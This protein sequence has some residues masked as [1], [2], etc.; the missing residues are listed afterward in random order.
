MKKQIEIS[1]KLPKLIGLIAICLSVSVFILSDIYDK[2]TSSDFFT[3]S[4]FINY[5]LALGYFSFILLRRIIFQGWNIFKLDGGSFRLFVVLFTISAFA[6]NRSMRAFS[7]PVLWLEIY[8]IITQIALILYA[9]KEKLSDNVKEAI[10]FI[11]GAGATIALY[12]SI[13]LFPISV[14]GLLFCWFFGISLNGIIQWIWLAVF[15]I[16]VFKIKSRPAKISFLT[17]AVIPIFIAIF[18][19]FK[20]SQT[21]ELVK[22]TNA[23]INKD[24]PEWVMLSQNLPDD[25]FTEWAMESD[26]INETRTD[27]WGF[28]MWGFGSSN[29]IKRHDPFTMIS[30]NILGDLGI[31]RDNQIKILETKFKYRHEAI[32]RLWSDDDLIT[33]N[34]ETEVELMPDY[35]LA[36]IEKK[37]TIENTYYDPHGWWSPEGEAVYTF[38]LPEGAVATSLSLWINGVEEKARLTTKEK[39]DSAYTTI[40]GVEVRDPSVVHWQ[41]GNRLIVRVFPCTPKEDRKFKLGVTVPLRINDN[42]LIFD[43]VYFQ[44]PDYSDTKESIEIIVKNAEEFKNIDIPKFFKKKN[45]KY[46][47]KGKY[48]ANWKIKM[49]KT[50]LSKKYFSFNGNSYKIKEITKTKENINIK[51]VYLDINNSWSE[52]KFNEI[53]KLIKE[54]NVFVFTN[55]LTQ[56][57]EDNRAGVFVKLHNLNFSLFPIYKIETPKNSLL[58]TESKSDSPMLEDLEN[59]AFKFFTLEYL[60]SNKGKIKLFDIGDNITSYLKVLKEYDSFD[61]ATGTIDELKQILKENT[62]P[63]IKEYENTVALETSNIAIVK[64][65]IAHKSE[66]PDHLLR[67]FAYNRIMNEIGNKFL[68]KEYINNEIINIAKEAYVVTPVSSLIVLE[69]KEDYDKFDIE[70]TDANTSLEN[71]FTESSGA[72]PE[73]HE[74]ALIIMGLLVAGFLFY[75]FKF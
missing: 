48:R 56:I 12:F 51:N 50:E 1:Q 58:I 11:F 57:T 22:D 35:R 25:Y 74:W 9:Y 8:I 16:P 64:D 66:A 33:K 63:I 26:L 14:F 37:I 67:L 10:F 21:Q 45:D 65:T 55:E 73:P 29:F 24:I 61:Y 19:M 6:L 30:H 42:E 2:G 3:G 39:A 31:Y 72:V 17:G 46:T 32:P 62:F 20:W 71:A 75:R 34:I 36:Y 13:V 60:K 47:Y 18:F 44:G 70:K 38:H 53:W 40:V 28:D 69:S 27:L 49:P 4:F 43:N 59:T 23:N 7:E 68:D 5:I 54:K 41:E 15:L 52:S